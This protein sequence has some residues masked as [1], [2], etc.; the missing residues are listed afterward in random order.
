MARPWS[1]LP[2]MSRPPGPIVSASFSLYLRSSSVRIGFLCVS[3]WAPYEALTQK[4]ED[5]ASSRRFTV[6]RLPRSRTL[7]G[8]VPHLEIRPSL[9][10]PRLSRRDLRRLLV[11]A[12]AGEE[13]RLAD[14]PQACRGHGLLRRA[15]DHSWR[16]AGLR[17]LLQAFAV[18]RVGEQRLDQVGAAAFVG[19]RHVVPRRSHRHLAR[20]PLSRAQGEA[21]LVAHPRL[22]RL[23][24][25]LRPVLR[26]PR[27]FR[28]PGIV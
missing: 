26:P 8:P 6:H 14:E 21:L 15:R 3:Q 16:A 13:A 4:G 27:Q 20:N 9:V 18:H 1:S 12:K 28:E 19:R 10:Q 23:L 2:R 24:C 7:S 5:L 11:S 22:C 25:A 17:A